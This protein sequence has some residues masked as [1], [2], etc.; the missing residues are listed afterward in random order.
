MAGALTDEWFSLYAELAADLP[1]HPGLDLVLD[2]EVSGAPDGKVRF[3]L[4]FADGRIAEV[5]SG[6]HGEADCSLAASYDDFRALLQGD[7][8]HDV[9]YM[10]GRLKVD[11]AYE[12]WLFPFDVV[13]RTPEFTEMLRALAA[14]SDFG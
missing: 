4:V 1:E 2:C 5:A 8:T 7:V 6:K 3:H 9:A 11:G 14:A 13:R 12:R 10:Q